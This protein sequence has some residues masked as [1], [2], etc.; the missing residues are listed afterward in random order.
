MAATLVVAAGP[1]SGRAQVAPAKAGAPASR[2]RA[3]SGRPAAAARGG[4]AAPDGSARPSR[5]L[6]RTSDLPYA[7][8]G[9]GSVLLSE[10]LE[11]LER[12]I[13]SH[14]SA[15]P[16]GFDAA[17]V[18]AGDVAGHALVDLGLSAGV[19][20]GG[21]L[22]GSSRF[23]RAGLHALETLVASDAVLLG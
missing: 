11:G 21:K 7:G 8:V 3:P 19:W 17:F 22:A 15:D 18:D 4:R 2:A 6:F 10:P 23:E 12:G 14:T 13:R 16:S 9:F 1:S 20:V 5:S